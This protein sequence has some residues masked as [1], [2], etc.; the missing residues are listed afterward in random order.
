M[1]KRRGMNQI[2]NLTPNHKP[3]KGKGQMSFDWGML[4]IVG[5][6]FLKVIK[7]CPC[8]FKIDLI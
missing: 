2:E 5:N 1:I 7:Y 4:Y 6:I 8:I 3:F